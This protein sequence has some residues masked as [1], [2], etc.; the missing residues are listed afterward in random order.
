MSKMQ[1]QLRAAIAKNLDQHEKADK[2]FGIYQSSRLESIAIQDIHPNP[3]QPRM[4]FNADELQELADSIA[5]I[6]LLQ[7]ITVRQT[8]NGYTIVDGERRLRAQKIL[9]KTSVECLVIDI[10]DERNA[11]LALAGNL[12]R[13]DLSDYETAQAIIAFKSSFSNKT[14][15]AKALG[16]SRA[17]IYKL[18]AFEELPAEVLHMLSV[19]PDLL[20]ADSAEKIK[21]LKKEL[22][23]PDFDAL[24]LSVIKLVQS[25]HIKQ[26][27]IEEYVRQAIENQSN[28]GLENNN[29]DNQSISDQSSQLRQARIP[30]Q[31]FVKKIYVKEGKSVGKIKNDGRKFTVEITAQFLTEDQEDKVI[32]F[33]NQLLE[34]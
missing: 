11:L 23:R 2:D 24:L 26:S 22:N 19:Q 6:G 18:F 3:A 34:P 28:A 10:N 32:K 5:E 33:L 29:S 31:S 12:S 15:F 4:N 9:G 25:Q 17:K 13:A 7:P 14:E 1:Q 30:A 8:A 20:S 16:I 21:T 27:H